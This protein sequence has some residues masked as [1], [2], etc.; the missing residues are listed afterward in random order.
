MPTKPKTKKRTKQVAGVIPPTTEAE[1]RI[2]YLKLGNASK[3]GEQVG[4][5]ARKGR[6]LAAKA[7]LEPEFLEAQRE[8]L[9]EGKREVSLL[10]L[11]IA[12]TL[13]TR[14]KEADLGPEELAQLMTKYQLRSFN[15]ANPKPAYC[16]ALASAAKVIDN[17]V[18]GDE[19]NNTKPLVVEI[20]MRE[21]EPDPRQ[22]P[23]VETS[24]NPGKS[25]DS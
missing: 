1:F 19:D 21:T 14:I 4:I 20:N 17:A 24:K 6:E 23:Y 5:S 15:Y 22:S 10:L 25:A 3:A 7:R 2:A 8:V 13:H 9:S 16:Q 12:R 18:A 11:D